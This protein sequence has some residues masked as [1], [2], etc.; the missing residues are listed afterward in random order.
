MDSLAL[1]SGLYRDDAVSSTVAGSTR[2]RFLGSDYRRMRR[3]YPRVQTRVRA[4]HAIQTQAATIID[5]VDRM[6][7]SV[8]LRHGVFWRS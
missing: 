7:D 8:G 5:Y 2:I 1:L 6:T 3:V 4:I